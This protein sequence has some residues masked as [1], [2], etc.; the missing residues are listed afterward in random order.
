MM[1]GMGERDLLTASTH[2]GYEVE[3]MVR[4]ALA[5]RDAGSAVVR[6]ALMES[7]L[8]HAR[9]LLE[10]LQGTNHPND[11]QATEFTPGWECSADLTARKKAIDRHLAHLT[12]SRVEEGTERWEFPDLLR[13]V[14]DAY[15]VFVRSA[16]DGPAS[17]NLAQ[18]LSEVDARLQRAADDVGTD[19][20]TLRL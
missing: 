6:I 5:S 2:V 14:L 20:L 17:A 11:I 1:N 16:P 4:A 7:A 15:R 13:E 9:A 18:K 10:F 12:W 3:Q 8:F 19:P